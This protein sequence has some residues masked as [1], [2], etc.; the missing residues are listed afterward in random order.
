MEEKYITE[1]LTSIRDIMIKW[2]IYKDYDLDSIFEEIMLL[3]E[4]HLSLDDDEI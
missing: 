2:S 4:I 1:M 3:V